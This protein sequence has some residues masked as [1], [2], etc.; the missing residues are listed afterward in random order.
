[1]VY[2]S[3]ANLT[4]FDS[5]SYNNFGNVESYYFPVYVYG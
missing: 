3:D 5:Y 1:M 4:I 2:M